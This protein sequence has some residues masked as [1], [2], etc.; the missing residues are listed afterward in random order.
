MKE[1]AGIERTC[2][3]KEKMHV[4][5]ILIRNEL[6]SRVYRKDWYSAY[7]ELVKGWCWW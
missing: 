2:A 7:P 6:G 5:F 3:D 1:D 4:L